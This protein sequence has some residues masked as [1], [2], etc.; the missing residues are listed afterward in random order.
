MI[1]GGSERRDVGVAGRAGGLK[2]RATAGEMLAAE[3]RDQ[4]VGREMRPTAV[5]IGKGCTELAMESHRDLIRSIQYRA[6][7]IT[8]APKST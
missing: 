4:N 6:S 5:S 7:S 8:H 3:L 2:V 1:V